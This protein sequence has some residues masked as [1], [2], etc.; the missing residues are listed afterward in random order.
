MAALLLDN[1]AN[2]N[3]RAKNGLTPMHL[4]AQEDRVSVA[5]VLV[6]NADAEID[7]QTKV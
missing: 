2:V 6:S 3:S 4:C 1:G 7:A 5:S